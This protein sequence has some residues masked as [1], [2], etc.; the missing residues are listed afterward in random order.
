MFLGKGDGFYAGSEGQA[1]RGLH[2]PTALCRTVQTLHTRH[3]PADVYLTVAHQHVFVINGA[4]SDFFN[5]KN[6]PMKQI[7]LNPNRGPVCLCMVVCHF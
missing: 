6:K 2:K 7:S 3:I 5:R 4:P 1:N